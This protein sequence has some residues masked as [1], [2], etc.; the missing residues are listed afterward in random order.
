MI[1]KCQ[2][3]WTRKAEH[4]PTRQTAGSLAHR[5][6]MLMGRIC[7]RTHKYTRMYIQEHGR[8]LLSLLQLC[9]ELRSPHLSSQS[10]HLDYI[11][12]GDKCLVRSKGL[13]S[14]PHRCCF[15]WKKHN[16]NWFDSGRTTNS[17]KKT[18]GFLTIWLLLTWYIFC[19]TVW[20]PWLMGTEIEEM[21]ALGGIFSEC[22]PN[23]IVGLRCVHMQHN[24]QH[25]PWTLNSTG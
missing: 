16:K 9:S 1:P 17:W 18:F 19:L 6:T 3:Y 12:R 23:V 10:I 8:M 7:G 14:F 25:G 20:P 5:S 24:M 15:W 13:V 21:Q 2:T 11:V 22:S 4:A